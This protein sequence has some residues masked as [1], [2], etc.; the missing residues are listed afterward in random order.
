MFVRSPPA[1]KDWK[2]GHCEKGKACIYRHMK[3]D[4]GY[5]ASEAD[6]SKEEK[7]KDVVSNKKLK[8]AKTEV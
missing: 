7:P 8:L 6:V 1:C 4:S 3:E 5:S 2:K